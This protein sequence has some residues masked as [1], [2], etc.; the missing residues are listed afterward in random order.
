MRKCVVAENRSIQFLIVIPAKAGTQTESQV[1]LPVE[2]LGP[3]FRRD[4]GMGLAFGEA[5]IP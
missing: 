2:S 3:G 5:S 1:L 4:D